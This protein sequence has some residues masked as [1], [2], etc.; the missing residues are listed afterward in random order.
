MGIAAE[1]C[2]SSS[3]LN[4]AIKQLVEASLFVLRQGK[5]SPYL[6]CIERIYP[7]VKAGGLT[8]GGPT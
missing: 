7:S 1:L 6:C 8:V 3:Q 5:A 2:L 4:S